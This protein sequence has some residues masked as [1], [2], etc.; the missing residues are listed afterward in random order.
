LHRNSDST[1]ES[2]VDNVKNALNPGGNLIILD[3]LGDQSTGPAAKAFTR[4]QALNLFNASGGQIYTF[5]E[6][7]FWLEKAG[8]VD[9]SRKKLSAAPLLG[10]IF[11]LKPGV[12]E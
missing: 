3:Q 8:F 4:L 11:A 12:D 2:L 6:I 10:L 7:S 1:N 9:I 5:S